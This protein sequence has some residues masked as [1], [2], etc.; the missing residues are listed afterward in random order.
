MRIPFL[1]LLFIPLMLLAAPQASIAGSKTKITWGQMVDACG[2]NNSSGGGHV[3]C[4]AQCGSHW[5]DYDCYGTG[6]CYKTVIAIVSR[7]PND[8]VIA[9]SRPGLLNMPPP[10]LSTSGSGGG[11]AGPSLR[12]Q[13]GQQGQS[14]RPI[15]AL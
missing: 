9:Q 4:T 14:G 7:P 2:T 8:P 13:Q 6:N 15:G 3:G 5:C 11:S 10:S 1:L 12:G